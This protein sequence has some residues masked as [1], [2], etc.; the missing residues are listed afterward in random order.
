MEDLRLERVIELPDIWIPLS[1]AHHLTE[2]ISYTSGLSSHDTCEMTR[3]TDRIDWTRE[4]VCES[5]CEYCK[6]LLMECETRIFFGGERDRLTV[7]D[8]I[9]VE[10]ELDTVRQYQ[11]C[12]TKISRELLRL[13]YLLQSDMHVLGFSVCDRESFPTFSLQEDKIRFAMFTSLRF[14]DN[15]E[16]SKF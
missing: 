7:S 4:E 1:I 8:T 2:V 15:V 13:L 9:L 5:I 3:A 6:V 10:S 11:F 12:I 14:V 16:L